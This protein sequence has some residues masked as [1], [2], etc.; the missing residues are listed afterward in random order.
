MQRY[1]GKGNLGILLFISRKK[2]SVNLGNQYIV[3][4]DQYNIKLWQIKITELKSLKKLEVGWVRMQE[5]WK[6]KVKWK[7]RVP[8]RI[9]YCDNRQLKTGY[10]HY[11]NKG[12]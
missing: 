4:R 7:Y 2:S 10:R 11:E 12:Y 6:L 1:K 5:K 3:A 8:V 9:L